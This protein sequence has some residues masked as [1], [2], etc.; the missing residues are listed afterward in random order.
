MYLNFALCRQ[1]SWEDRTPGNTV[2]WLQKIDNKRVLD[3]VHIQ[4]RNDY[5]LDVK[6]VQRKS[7]ICYFDASPFNLTV[8]AQIIFNY[9][10][11][12][13]VHIIKLRFVDYS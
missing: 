9:L 4:Y 12:N 1:D 6:K 13:F 8:L 3:D 11:T 7:E 10:G 5:N 2:V